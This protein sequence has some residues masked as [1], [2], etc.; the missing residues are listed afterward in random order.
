MRSFEKSS[1]LEHVC[2][3]IRGPVMDE[4]NRLE[5]AATRFKLNI[6]NRLPWFS[7]AGGDPPSRE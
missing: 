7:C 1:K 6:R 2:Y 3:D 5:A 4:A